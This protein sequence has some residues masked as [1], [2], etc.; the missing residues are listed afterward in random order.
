M[1]KDLFF[2]MDDDGSGMLEEPEIK[3]LAIALG[4]KLSH[5]EAVAG[6]SIAIGSASWG[7]APIHLHPSCHVLFYVTL[8]Y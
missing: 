4:Q 2:S 6:T 3:M 8:D 5:N 7:L 1:L